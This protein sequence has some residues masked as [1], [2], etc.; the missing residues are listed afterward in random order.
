MLIGNKNNLDLFNNLL[1]PLIPKN[2]ELYIEP[3]GG[4]FGLYE[5]L[6][7]KSHSIRYAIYNDINELLLH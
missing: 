6:K 2:I 7:S 5:L 3:F 1:G 4:E